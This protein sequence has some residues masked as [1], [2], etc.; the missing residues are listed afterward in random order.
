MVACSVSSVITDIE[1]AQTVLTL[2]APVIA[3]FAGPGALLFQGYIVAASNGL[4]CVLTAAQAAGA[5][6]ATVATAFGT[7]FA[8]AAVPVLPPGTP[9]YVA[10]VITSVSGLIK[11]LIEKYGPH[12]NQ[13][14]ATPVKIKLGM[15]DHR[16]ISDVQ[17]KLNAVTAQF[18]K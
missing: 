11:V 5:T 15:A 14:A 12:P 6:T 10:A 16:R 4:G 7:C 8:A 1:I 18:K 9:A 13:A 3:A 2:G 17:A